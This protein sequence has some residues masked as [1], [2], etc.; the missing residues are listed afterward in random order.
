MES[1]AEQLPY[2]YKYIP[3]EQTLSVDEAIKK[4]A[5]YHNSNH[6]NVVAAFPYLQ[7][8]TGTVSFK[9]TINSGYPCIMMMGSDAQGIR[10]RS[11][12]IDN[13]TGNPQMRC[14]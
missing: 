8:F 13:Y 14:G 4:I 5:Y 7:G 12:L 1:A 2:F 6:D 3:L 11:E 9:E 10:V